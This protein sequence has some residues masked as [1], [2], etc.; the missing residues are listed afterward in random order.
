MYLVPEVFIGE[1]NGHPLQCSCLGNSLGSGA[2]WAA[3]HGSQSVGHDWATNTMHGV[4]LLAHFPHCH[5]VPDY[6]SVIVQSTSLFLDFF[7]ESLSLPSFRRGLCILHMGRRCIWI[8]R[9]IKKS[10]WWS[11][12]FFQTLP[13]G[14]IWCQDKEYI[15]NLPTCLKFGNK[16]W[17]IKCK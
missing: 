12:G 7:H 13:S 15:S 16:F 14:H 1:G 17:S 6:L 5:V 8:V 3:L 9:W 2:W 11:Y 10:T 4:F